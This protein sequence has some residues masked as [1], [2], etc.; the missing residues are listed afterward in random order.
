MIMKVNVDVLKGAALR[1]AVAKCQDQPVFWHEKD[2]DLYCGCGCSDNSYDP[3]EDWAQGGPIIE[4]EMISTSPTD[5]K[6][7]DYK[8]PWSAYYRETLFDDCEGYYATGPTPLVAAMRCYV[9]SKLG[10]EIDIPEEL[11]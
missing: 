2:R 11:I 5:P 3:T 9:T 1:W 4:R 6:A 7:I 10:D 8:E